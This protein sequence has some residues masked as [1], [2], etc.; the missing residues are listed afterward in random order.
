MTQ[1]ATERDTLERFRSELNRLGFTQSEAAR[2]IGIS[3]STLTQLLNGSYGAD[4][5]AKI[6]D[7]EKWLNKVSN[8]LAGLPKGPEWVQTQSATRIINIL[9][10]AQDSAGMTLIYGGSGVGKTTACKAY[11]RQYPNVWIATMSTAKNSVSAALEELALSVGMSEIPTRASRIERETTNRLK[12]T[13]GL[14]IIDEA[15]NLDFKALEALRSVYDMSGI[16]FTFVG[17]ESIYTRMNSG[18]QAPYLT[19]LRGRISKREHLP[20]VTREDIEVVAKDFGMRDKAA[21]KYL[22]QIGLKPGC[23]RMVVN[24][25][26]MAIMFADGQTPDL[27]HIEAASKNLGL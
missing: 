19:L 5:K 3:S 4:P 9:N 24:V 1:N 16:G 23:L 26:R 20:K 18:K 22:C 25:M 10:Y 21:L 8:S 17:N 13:Q 15:Q 6:A 27:S 11:Q 14:V 7:I 12:N 2:Q